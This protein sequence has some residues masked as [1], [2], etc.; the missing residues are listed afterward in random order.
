MLTFG[1]CV[2][3]VL[4]VDVSSFAKIS[5]DAVARWVTLAAVEKVGRVPCHT[6]LDCCKNV[7]MQTSTSSVWDD[8]RNDL[9]FI[10]MLLGFRSLQRVVGSTDRGSNPSGARD[11]LH[12][13]HSCCSWG[14]SSLLHIEYLVSFLGIN[15]LCVV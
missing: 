3:F 7:I 4:S 9:W 13:S 5:A 11:S 12:H 8:E 2:T 6:F 15:C 10:Y 1:S 14:P